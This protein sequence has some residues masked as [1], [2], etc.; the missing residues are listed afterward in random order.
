MKKEK[1]LSGL[2]VEIAS[3]KATM[4][5]KFDSLETQISD[6]KSVITAQWERFVTNEKMK[7]ELRNMNAKIDTVDRKYEPMRNG[8]WKIMSI[9]G[10]AIIIALLG[11]ILK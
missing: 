3:M 10:G 9:A 2:Q 11:L 4:E 7:L 6:M 8:L 5:S 1:D